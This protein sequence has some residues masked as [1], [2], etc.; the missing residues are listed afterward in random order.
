MTGW[1]TRSRTIALFFSLATA[2]ATATSTHAASEAFYRT[3]SDG[4]G[5]IAVYRLT[6]ERYRE[7][8]V[9]H[10]IIVTVSEEI[11]ADT[12]VKVESEETPPEKRIYVLKQNF[13]RKFATGIYDY[14]TETS[15]FV[16]PESHL[17]HAPF[18]AAR[19]THTTQEWCGHVY[20]RLDLRS[21]GWRLH[22]HSYFE[23]EGDTE[24]L[25]PARDTWTE[26]ALWLT[27]R[28]LDGEWAQPG[29][30]KTLQLLPALWETRKSHRPTAPVSVNVQKRDAETIA[31]AFGVLLAY[32]WNWSVGDRQVTV[33]VEASAPHRILAWTDSRGGEA[34]IVA[35]ERLPYWE[36]H[37]EHAQEVRERLGLPSMELPSM[38][39]PR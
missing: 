31:T 8:H 4:K 37:D 10:A 17:G 19:I 29:E 20:Q 32:P 12:Y 15:T 7:P 30:T 25:I 24:R 13:L 36:L 34:Q 6:E 39:P 21:D 1:M 16:A 23:A 3:W 35:C 26:D 2:A 28:E 33:W 11:N 38:N 22:G 18:Q 14:S 9:G 5:E 27:I